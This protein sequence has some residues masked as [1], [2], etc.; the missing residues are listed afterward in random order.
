MSVAGIRRSDRVCLTLFL[1]AEG[2]DSEGRSFKEQA[3]TMLIS[4]HGAVVVLNR[5]LAAGQQVQIR[6]KASHESHRHGPV[7][8]IGLFG[9]QEEG[10]VYG[11][12]FVDAENDLWGVEF[13][14]IAESQEAVAR[15][16][17]ECCYCGGREVAYL[18]E[19]ELA[20]FES[21]RCIARLC[22]TC[23]VPSIWAQAPHEDLKKARARGNGHAIQAQTKPEG[24]L[25]ERRRVVRLKARLTACVREASADD[26]LAVCEEI[27]SFGLSFRSRKRYTPKTRIE[28]AVPYT[29]GSANIFVAAQV[30]HSE[31]IP[32]AGLF[33]N[34]IEYL[35]PGEFLKK[36]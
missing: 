34:G 28:I 24:T 2:T 8:I 11:V 27:S 26:E 19:L 3:R 20:G 21:N 35:K 22:K 30:V 15:M 31:E 6:R 1:E 13:P 33:R 29:Q 4:R 25:G 5:A 36:N 10:Y 23:G 18:N 9:H 17:L 14:P 32:T 7:R 12:S 16:L